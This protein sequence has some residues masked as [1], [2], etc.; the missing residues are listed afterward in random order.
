MT[1]QVTL[2]TAEKQLENDS[3]GHFTSNNFLE[4]VG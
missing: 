4:E 1:R 3:Y 2:Y